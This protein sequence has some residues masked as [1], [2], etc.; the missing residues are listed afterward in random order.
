MEMA[1]NGARFRLPDGFIGRA[2]RW[3]IDEQRGNVSGQFLMADSAL[4]VEDAPAGLTIPVQV[5]EDVITIS[6]GSG[7]QTVRWLAAAAAQQY[8]LLHTAHGRPR[9]REPQRT[10]QGHFLASRVVYVPTGSMLGPTMQLKEVAALASEAGAC[11]RCWRGVRGSPA[12]PCPGRPPLYPS[13][14]R[15]VGVCVPPWRRG[16]D[17]R[18]RDGAAPGCS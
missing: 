9:Q 12:A 3:L 15:V 17:G 10:P 2:R 11:V 5:G 16:E 6:C 13:E 14:H 1:P 7:E 18:G 4:S 8:T